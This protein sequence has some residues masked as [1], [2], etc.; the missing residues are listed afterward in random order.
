MANNELKSR[1]REIITQLDALYNAKRPGGGVHGQVI[2]MEP[3]TIRTTGDGLQC[4]SDAQSL[5]DELLDP[6]DRRAA[7]AQDGSD[8]A[9]LDWLEMAMSTN[10]SCTPYYDDKVGFGYPYL[11]NGSPMGGGVGF[12]NTGASLRNA[13]DAARLAAIQAQAGEGVCNA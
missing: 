1:A 7:P 6:F 4:V 12:Y 10:H 5:L 8:T 9:R 3:W 13:I 11:V 2:G